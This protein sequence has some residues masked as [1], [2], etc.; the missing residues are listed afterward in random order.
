MKYYKQIKPYTKTNQLEKVSLEAAAVHF[1]KIPTELLYALPEDTYSK[2]KNVLQTLFS[3]ISNI[4]LT[5]MFTVNETNYG[6]IPGLDEMSYGEYLDLIT[7]TEK[8]MWDNIPI[9]MSILYR[10][11]TKQLGKQYIIQPYTGTNDDRIELFKHVL[12]M[13]VVFGATSFF[14]HLQKD[15]LNATLTYSVEILKEKGNK[16]T[17]ALLETLQK[18]GL[19]IT[20]LASLQIMTSPE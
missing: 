9:V 7:Y 18:S 15:L 3:T 20:H 10:P 16:E 11:V 6:F 4:S 13:D 8:N 1:C 5:N 2:V 17:L 14:L 12:T 19:D